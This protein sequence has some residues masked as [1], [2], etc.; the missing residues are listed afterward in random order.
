MGGPFLWAWWVK[1]R[2]PPDVGIAAAP[3][4][5]DEQPQ[6]PQ[7]DQTTRP[8]QG[9]GVVDDLEP[10]SPNPMIDSLRQMLNDSPVFDE[11]GDE[12]R[13]QLD[14]ADAL[15]AKIKAENREALDRLKQGLSVRRNGRPTPRGKPNLIVVDLGRLAADSLSCYNDQA[16]ATRV[17]DHLAKQGVRFTRFYR[18]TLD[19]DLQRRRFVRADVNT[20]LHGQSNVDTMPARLI[21]AGYETTIIGNC[22]VAAD[23][24]KIGFDA[25]FGSTAS[26]SLE[27]AWPETIFADGAPLRLVLDDGERFD[28]HT[29]YMTEAFSFA[30]RQRTTQPF[31]LWLS[32]PR[33]DVQFPADPTATAPPQPM[34]EQLSQIEQ[35]LIDWITVLNKRSIA[36]NSIVAV[37]S[38]TAPR[39]LEGE[40]P[41][42]ERRLRAPLIVL[43]PRRVSAKTSNV[44]CTPAD[45]AETLVEFAGGDGSAGADAVSLAKTLLSKGNAPLGRE[46]IVWREGEREVVVFDHWRYERTNGETAILYDLDSSESPPKNVAG[47]HPQVV[48]A[49]KQRLAKAK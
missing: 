40:D 38:L 47:L 48:V 5:T 10:P 9:N 41:L 25:W 27:H 49:A 34:D 12:L 8:R 19:K 4:A 13:A 17:F 11:H 14:E 21:D 35:Q 33:P 29:I 15:L 45:L 37:T 20:T 43:G 39:P 42:S 22:S 32:L 26:N 46:S 28:S 16:P 6:E 7:S 18:S 23:P 31:L 30:K 1:S 3:N 2:Q 44:L 36:I 24:H